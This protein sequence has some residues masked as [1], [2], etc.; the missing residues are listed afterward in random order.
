[1]SKTSGKEPADKYRPFKTRR[2]LIRSISS[3][4]LTG[5][6]VYIALQWSNLQ[7]WHWIAMAAVLTVILVV[8][9][10]FCGFLCPVGSTLAL[11]HFLCKKLHIKEIRRPEKFNRFIRIFRYFFCV[12]YFV[13]HF[14]LGIDPGWAL[15]VLL[16][17]TTPF[18]VRFWCSICPV[19][20]ILGLINRIGAFR[21]QKNA[22]GCVGCSACEKVCPMQNEK[23]FTC[24][25][26]GKVFSVSCIYC[27]KCVE[28]C[29]KDDVLSLTA[30]GK[31][32]L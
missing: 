28:K 25:K 16:I 21:L 23:V 2:I 13:L 24:D 29:P 10:G 26:T 11:I 14:G 9:R 31:K 32:I 5:F 15:V 17:I 6:V 1:M 7:I 20:T 30:A 22:E 12:F 18:M 4:L 27:G 3:V 19:G 8:G